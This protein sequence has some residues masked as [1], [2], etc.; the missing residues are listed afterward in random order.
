MSINK[1]LIALD[2]DGV[3]LDY[4][5]AYANLWERAFGEKLQMKDPQGHWVEN[6]Y[7][8][9]TL[10]KEE[11]KYF[12]KFFKDEFWSTI[13]ALPGAVEACNT[14]VD[15]GNEIICV[16]AVDKEWEAARMH[17]LKNLGFKVQAVVGTGNN[18]HAFNSKAVKIEYY[19][20]KAEY[21]N[22]LKP[23]VFV[24]DYLMYHHGV[25][26]SIHKAL[27]LR[28]PNGRIDSHPTVEVHSRHNNLSEFAQFWLNKGVDNE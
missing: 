5:T 12:R 11:L 6:R 22:W 8:V 2:G 25:D 9:R 28:E 16:T 1:N 19:S 27:I 26:N 15:A 4:I 23:E 17:N 21:L 14:L 7:H 13:P 20:P 10:E 3:M 18:G 24:D